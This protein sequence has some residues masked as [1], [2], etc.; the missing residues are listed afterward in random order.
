VT[1]IRSLA[2]LAAL[3]VAATA[4]LLASCNTVSGVGQDLQDASSAVQNR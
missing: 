1:L 3:S 2:A 4:L